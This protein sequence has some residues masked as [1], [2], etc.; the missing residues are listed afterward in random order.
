MEIFGYFMS[1]LMGVLLGM[2]GAG[3]SIL[4]V[5]ILVYLF[6]VSPVLAT[7]SS[8]FIVGC[9]ALVGA[10]KSIHKKELDLKLGGVFAAFSFVGI[11]ISRSL[12][13]PLLPEV[14]Y[15]VG[16]LKIEKG[17]LIL[18]SFALLML[19]AA[20]SMLRPSGPPT[21][22]ALNK[23][24]IA[25]YGFAVGLVT[26]FVGAGG[27]FLIVPALVNILGL[28]MRSAVG[29]S[30]LVVAANSFFG[31]FV[32]LGAK[33]TT[34]DWVLMFSILACALLGLFFGSFFT[35]KIKEPS[36]KRAFGVFVLIAGTL[37]VLEQVYSL[38]QSSL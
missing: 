29:T 18:V 38:L 31:F 25:P 26:G 15:Q 17:F 13:L 11:F 21:E 14:L 36:L 22:P 24:R 2:M 8:L 28:S 23:G 1:L 5:P 35:E 32:S 4:T 27:G 10:A 7:T 19:M 20:R 12:L 34:V 16:T 30:M 9:T 33:E 3:G 6:K 37:I